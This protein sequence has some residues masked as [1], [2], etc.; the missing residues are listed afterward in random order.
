MT[1]ARYILLIPKEA[2]NAATDERMTFNELAQQSVDIA[3]SLAHIGVKKKDIVVICS[4]NRMEYIPIAFGTLLAGAVLANINENKEIINRDTDIEKTIVFDEPVEGAIRFKDFLSQHASVED[5]EA[6]PVNGCED[7]AIILFSSGTTGM[8]KGV[9]F[10]HYSFLCSAQDPSSSADEGAVLLGSVD[11]SNSYGIV[12]LFRHLDGG[13]VTVIGADPDGE[14]T[15]DIIQKYKLRVDCLSNASWNVVRVHTI[16]T[17]PTTIAAINS[18]KDISKY[19]TS[20]L[21][22]IS[23]CGTICNESI[24]DTFKKRIPSLESVSHYYGLTEVGCINNSKFAKF[25]H[26]Q[27]SV[28]CVRNVFVVKIVDVE[29]REPLGP[30]QRG[31]ICCKS[32]TLLQGYIGGEIDYL[33]EEGFF[34]T[35][36]LGYYDEDQYIYVVDRI[37]DIIKHNSCTVSPSELEAVL[38]QHPSVHDVGVVGA[39]HG[40]TQELPTAFVVLKPGAQVTEQELIDFFNK[41]VAQNVMQLA[42]GVHFINELPRGAGLKLDRKKL[43]SML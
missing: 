26:R 14:Q 25:G 43:R 1:R 3:L 16:P 36:D 24:L 33:D 31:E 11:W 21:R 34:K 6:T 41:N 40:E 37:K 35:G 17:L 30:H 5:F 7:L 12:I 22:K 28:G 29:T 39:P 15:L 19:D 23:V 18:V 10:T 27:G 2:I 32:P 9:K 38:L 8:P 42:G 20:S 4:S 13:F